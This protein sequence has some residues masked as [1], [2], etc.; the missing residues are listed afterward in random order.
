MRSGRSGTV[1]RRGLLAAAIAG[2]AGFGGSA[3][4]AD[5]AARA[6]AVRRL[7]VDDPGFALRAWARLNGDPAG[8]TTWSVHGGMVYG[9]LPQGDDVTLAAFARR[10]YQYRACVVRR[11]RF[12]RDGALRLRTRAWTW[13]ADAD[14]G[15]LHREF[16]NPYTGRRVHCPPRM[17]PVGEQ[18]M[19]R[20]G[21]PPGAPRPFPAES[22]L[23]GRPMRLDYAVM[24]PHVWARREQFSRFRP[25]DATWFKLE[26]DMV[27]HAARLDE[28]LAPGLDHVANTMAHNLVAEWQTWMEMHGTP[29][30]ILF[31]GQGTTVF[32][33]ADLPAPVQAAIEAEFPGTLAASPGAP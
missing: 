8:R 31:V 23:D 10:L 5:A 12:E 22:S 33:P 15:A 3:F 27:T 13:Y 21:P 25:P 26:A 28:L 20:E 7:P 19:T 4:P 2:G 30:H 18:V 29:G 11:M 16:V 1:D 24:G 6:E 9:F 14:T 17:S 32:R